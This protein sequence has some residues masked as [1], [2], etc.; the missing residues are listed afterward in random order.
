MLVCQSLSVDT[1]GRDYLSVVCVEMCVCIPEYLNVCVCV[2]WSCMHVLEFVYACEFES[3][4]ACG[5]TYVWI[6]CVRVCVC[7][8]VLSPG[9]HGPRYVGWCVR[10]CTCRMCVYRPPL[11]EHAVCGQ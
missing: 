9:M 1:F 11:C 2:Y 10:W 8:G 3:R 5:H 4:Y 6:M 7:T